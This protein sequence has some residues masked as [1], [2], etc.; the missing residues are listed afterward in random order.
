GK[1]AFKAA[2]ECN[3]M[4]GALGDILLIRGTNLDGTPIAPHIKA[5]VAGGGELRRVGGRL[6]NGGWWHGWRRGEFVAERDAEGWPYWEQWGKRIRIE[7]M[8]R[9]NWFGKS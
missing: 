3:I 9:L 2:I 1:G 7:R 6:P 8:G 5:Q 4:E